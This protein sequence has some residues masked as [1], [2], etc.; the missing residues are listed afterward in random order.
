MFTKEQKKQIQLDFKSY[1][2]GRI[3]DFTDYSGDKLEQFVFQLQSIGCSW[4]STYN[5]ND[6]RESTIGYL[7]SYDKKVGLNLNDLTALTHFSTDY[8]LSKKDTLIGADFVSKALSK[9][10]DQYS[11]A[12]ISG[13]VNITE[14]YCKLTSTS[15]LE[16]LARLPGVSLDLT[17]TNCVHNGDKN[18]YNWLISTNA[19]MIHA[20][21][22]ESTVKNLRQVSFTQYFAIIGGD[23]VCF[24]DKDMHSLEDNPLS[25]FNLTNDINQLQDGKAIKIRSV[26]SK[27]RQGESPRGRELSGRTERATTSSGHLG[28][29]A[30]S[31]DS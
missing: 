21:S 5:D 29:E 17:L 15:Q 28:N 10:I 27:I 8:F 20:V 9:I 6:F 25:T 4:G 30:F 18:G 2:K 12:A 24:S 31:S 26:S 13:K 22:S 19:N 3:V 11:K 1:L 23:Y 14:V 7:Q 16:D